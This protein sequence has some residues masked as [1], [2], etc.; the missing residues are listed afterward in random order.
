[1][2]PRTLPD[3]GGLPGT[4]RRARAGRRGARPERHRLDPGSER[5][6]GQA[7]VLA[8]NGK[9]VRV[10]VGLTAPAGATVIEATGKT[11]DA[12][13]DRLP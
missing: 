10:G 6:R 9:I 8:E 1:M 4:R 7:D 12:R 11:R 13:A 5:Q 2:S 3:P